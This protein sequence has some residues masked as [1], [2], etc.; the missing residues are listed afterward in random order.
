MYA[1]T[2]ESQAIGNVIAT[3]QEQTNNSK[4]DKLVSGM[5]PSM[6]RVFPMPVLVLDQVL[7]QCVCCQ[8]S[9]CN[10]SIGHFENLAIHSVPTSPSSSP[11]G[12]RV[13]S[14]L[15][16]FDRAV[17]LRSLNH[18]FRVVS[19]M[20][21]M[22]SV[23]GEWDVILDSGADTNSLPLCFADVGIAG[24]APDTCFVDAQGSFLNVRATRVANI[25][26][27]D[28]IFRERFIVSDITCPLFSLGGVSRSG[29]N[30]MH[31]DGMPFLTKNDK[32]I[33]TLFKNNSL[34][35][36]AQFQF[37]QNVTCQPR[38]LP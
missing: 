12:L 2:V 30:V 34:C 31:I 10:S 3:R 6:R 24:P 17:G 1:P 35:A 25:K 4:L 13:L 19:S 7:K 8:L 22:E 36:R 9:P 16:E 28:V 37:L 23:T 38:S 27:G 29:W 11:Q 20:D 32:R 21:Y 14:D 5:T 26:F 33:K 15:R 18:H